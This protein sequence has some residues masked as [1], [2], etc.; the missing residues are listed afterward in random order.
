MEAARTRVAAMTDLEVYEENL[1]IS[2]RELKERIRELLAMLRGLAPVVVWW[3]FLLFL[4][5]TIDF[6][7]GKMDLE[8]LRSPELKG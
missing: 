2:M 4:P 7:T 6:L 3:L 8:Q 5:R 1:I